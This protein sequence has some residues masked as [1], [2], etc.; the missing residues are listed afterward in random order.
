M[1]N[2]GRNF[3]DYRSSCIR[4]AHVA[5][6]LGVEEGVQGLRSSMQDPRQV[7]TFMDWSRDDVANM[8]LSVGEQH[9]HFS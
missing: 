3:T 8:C 4:E 1:Q 6:A 7:R 5:Q 2:D 9:C